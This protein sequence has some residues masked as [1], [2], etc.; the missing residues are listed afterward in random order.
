MPERNAVGAIR[1]SK[2]SIKRNCLM[3]CATIISLIDL[4]WSHISPSLVSCMGGG[5]ECCID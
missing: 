1:V 4:L 2:V 5:L 3:N